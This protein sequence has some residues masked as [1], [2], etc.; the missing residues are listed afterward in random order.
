MNSE[1]GLMIDD[2]ESE[3]I[4]ADQLTKCRDIV[5]NMKDSIPVFIKAIEM[6]IYKKTM[7]ALD[8]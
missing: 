1:C 2:C 4:I 7:I 3:T 8:F 5:E 6:A